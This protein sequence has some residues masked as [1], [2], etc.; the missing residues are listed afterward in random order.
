MNQ[1][2]PEGED[3]D[4]LPAMVVHRRQALKALTALGVGT[5]TFQRALAAQAGNE[6]KVTPEMIKQ[7]EWIAGLELTDK[8]REETAGTLQ[9]TLRSFE[10]LRKVESQPVK[11]DMALA[12]DLKA[13]RTNPTG[14]TLLV[15]FWATWCGSC[16]HEFPDFEDTFRM[17][18]V[19]D[20]ELVTVAANMPDEKNSVM[21]VLEK[22]HATGRSFSVSPRIGPTKFWSIQSPVLG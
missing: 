21:R 10:A 11:L 2:I 12:A 9:G 15:S 14:K 1:G 18:S 20:L 13:L 5:V 19:R 8:E 4:S 16:L 7:A 6:G 22:M 3:V 17:Y